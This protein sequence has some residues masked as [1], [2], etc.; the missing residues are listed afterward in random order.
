MKREEVTPLDTHGVSCSVISTAHS[1]TPEHFDAAT[2]FS[3]LG[4]A[5]LCAAAF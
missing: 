2:K 1:L 5:S 3:T 4:L